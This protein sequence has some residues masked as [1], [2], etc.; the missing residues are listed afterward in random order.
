MTVLYVVAGL[1]IFIFPEILGSIIPGYEVPKPIRNWLRVCG[2][3]VVGLTLLVE[4][5]LWIGQP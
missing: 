3:A 2:A 5:L 1:I 4:V